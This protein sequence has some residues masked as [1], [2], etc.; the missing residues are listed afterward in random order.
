M[1]PYIRASSLQC[2]S[3]RWGRRLVTYEKVRAYDAAA[4]EAHRR[5]LAKQREVRAVQVEHIR[6]TPRL[7]KALVVSFQLV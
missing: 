2:L 4:A 7:L 3:T 1:H 5:D 6:L